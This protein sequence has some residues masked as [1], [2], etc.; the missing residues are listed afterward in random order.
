M[1]AWKTRPIEASCRIVAGGRE[2]R[3][4]ERRPVRAHR[5]RHRQ[6]AKIEQVDEIG[7]GAEPAV[8]LD[9]IGQ[10]LLDGVDGRH[11]RQQQCVD[12]AKDVI[13]H[14]PQLFELI[15]GRERIDRGRPRAGEDDLAR[16]RMHRLVRGRDQRARRDIALGEP[17]PFIEQARGFVERLDVDL[18]NDRAKPGNAR[19][20]RLVGRCRT[21][22]RRRTRA[23]PA[24]GTPSRTL[25]G[26]AP[27]MPERARAR[28]WIGGIGARHRGERA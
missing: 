6:P 26:I 27:G 7:V 20:R 19:Q 4:P 23:G 11:G 18:D 13:A 21:C 3:H 14:A 25:C 9:R 28:I 17:G 5:G 8:E 16:H 1:S 2:Q 24:S 22:G 12:L 15:E 10:H